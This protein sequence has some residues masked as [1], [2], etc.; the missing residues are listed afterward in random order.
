MAVDVKGDTICGAAQSGLGAMPPGAYYEILEAAKAAAAGLRHKV[1]PFLDL[2]DP[3][4]G[5]EV[6]TSKI[7]FFAK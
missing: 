3:G 7:G 1:G 6:F 2:E 5:A 4:T